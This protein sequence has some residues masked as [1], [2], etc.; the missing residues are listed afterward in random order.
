MDTSINTPSDEMKKENGMSILAFSI[1]IIF[2]S[3]AIMVIVNVSMKNKG[4]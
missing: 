4:R 2:T 3:V 1:S